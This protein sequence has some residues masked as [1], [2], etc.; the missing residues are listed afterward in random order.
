[1]QHTLDL[2]QRRLRA[3]VPVADFLFDELYP[4][5][6]RAKS[7]AFWTPVAVALRATELL[8]PSRGARV[9]DVGAGVG[10]FCIVG[11]ARA[12]AVF[13]GIEQRL[14]LV[15]A[16]ERAARCLG[17][18][19]AHFL[20]GA[21]EGADIESFDAVYLFNPFEENLWPPVAQLDKTVE[22]SAGRFV[23]DVA[24]ARHVLSRARPGTRVVT[25]HGLGAAM[26]PNYERVSCEP[27]HSGALDLWIKVDACA[28]RC[29]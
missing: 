1:M 29:G 21:F 26:P 16:A 27:I 15:L 11:A 19:N 10:K 4:Y 28:R 6:L 25:Y 23:R 22:L 24:R 20:H 8:A 13:V 5:S 2:M 9:L 12:D 18:V 14:H 7:S 3:G 17:A